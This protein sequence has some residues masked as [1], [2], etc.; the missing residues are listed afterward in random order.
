MLHSPV[1]ARMHAR[2][3]THYHYAN[4][5][6][7]TKPKISN[8]YWNKRHATTRSPQG[9]PIDLL[10][11]AETYRLKF[12]E[13]PEIVPPTGD[14]TLEHLSLWGHLISKP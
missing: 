11:P 7:K 12:P 4:T 5:H 9:L 2:A 14:L 8:K 6:A 3:H 13:P 10:P 1:P